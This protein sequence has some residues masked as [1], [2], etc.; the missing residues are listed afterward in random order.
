MMTVALV[1]MVGVT[2]VAATGCKGSSESNA[3]AENSGQAEP[4][5][6]KTVQ[7]TC[8]MHPE[9]VQNKPG[10]CPKCGMKLVEKR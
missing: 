7:Y 1:A 5:S 4:K 10:D 3:G 6:E 8:S 2:A 9:V